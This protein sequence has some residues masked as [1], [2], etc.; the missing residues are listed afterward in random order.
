MKIMRMLTAVVPVMGSTLGA[1][2]G[3]VFDEEEKEVAFDLE[4]FSATFTLATD[5]VF[6]GISQTDSKPA[7]QGSL[8]YAYPLG[9]YLGVWGSNLN[10]AI[11]KGGVELDFYLGYGTEL[12]TN[13]NIDLAVFYYSYPGG[14]SDPEPDYF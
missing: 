12:F 10:S 13:F 6:R 5:Y 14:G 8:D 2:V 9:I 11:S 4:N 1:G 3:G 7:V